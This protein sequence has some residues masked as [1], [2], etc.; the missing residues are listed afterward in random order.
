MAIDIGVT[1][2]GGEDV[3]ENRVMILRRD[4]T[5]WG[6][7]GWIIEVVDLRESNSTWERQERLRAH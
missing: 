3:V 5:L 2:R 7:E 4:A 6:S 1:N